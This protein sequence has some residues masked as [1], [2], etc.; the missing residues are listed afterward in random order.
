MIPSSRIV[1]ESGRDPG[2]RPPMS[3][4]WAREASR[5][6][7]FPFTN[8]GATQVTSGRCVPPRKG[9]LRMKTSPGE[10]FSVATDLAANDIDP[11]CIGIWAACA[12]I[13][14]SE[15]KMAQERSLLSFIFGENPALT[16]TEPISSAIVPRRLLK[17]SS[18]K[19]FNF[20][21]AK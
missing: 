20:I 7:G 1:V 14:P 13:S 8:T 19:S 10:R 21:R 9:S 2:V 11:R 5:N 15:L 18:S 17:I 3:A 4:W 6:S 12:I 16:S